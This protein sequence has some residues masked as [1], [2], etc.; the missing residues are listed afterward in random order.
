MIAYILTEIASLVAVANTVVEM[1]R[2][3]IFIKRIP[4]RL[5]PYFS[6]CHLFRRDEVMRLDSDTSYPE[7]CLG[8]LGMRI[9][10]DVFVLINTI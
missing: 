1:W 9:I 8:F 2:Q 6:L 3:Y 10:E 4:M 7:N 5:T